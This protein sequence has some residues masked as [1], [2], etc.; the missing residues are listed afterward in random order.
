MFRV[1]PIVCITLLSGSVAQV[2]AD[3]PFVFDTNWRAFFTGTSEST[4]PWFPTDQTLADFDGDGDLDIAVA[5]RGSATIYRVS[6]LLN[7]GDGLFAPPVLYPIADNSEAI[8]SADFDGD[9]DVDILVSEDGT[10]N[11]GDTVALLRNNGDGTFAPREGVTVHPS[12]GATGLAAADL[13]GDGDIDFASADFGLIGRGESVSIRMNSGDG[14]F[15]DG[16]TLN[17]PPGPSGIIIAQLIGSPLPDIAVATEE[18]T[19]ELFENQD[20]SFDRTSLSLP[21]I[22]DNIFAHVRAADIDNDGDLDLGVVGTA[23]VTDGARGAAIL[24]NNGKGFDAAAVYPFGDFVSGASQLAFGELTGDGNLDLVG[25]SPL[26]NE[27]YILPGDGRGAFGSA[28]ERLSGRYPHAVDIADID[29]DGDGDV[30]ITSELSNAVSIHEN[31]GI[32][33][34]AFP[35]DKRAGFGLDNISIASGDIDNDGDLDVVSGGNQINVFVNLGDGTYQDADSFDPGSNRGSQELALHDLD[36]DTFLDLLWIPRDETPPYHFFV[37]TND[38]TGSFGPVQAWEIDTCG[39]EDIDA[40]DLDLDGDLDIVVTEWLGCQNVPLSAR[41]LFIAENLGDG[42]FNLLPPVVL[43]QPW[44]TAVAFGDFNEDGIPDLA[45]GTNPLSVGI[46]NG[47]LSYEYFEIG[48]LGIDLDVNDLNGD[49]HLDIVSCV[50]D[51]TDFRPG[52][53]VLLGNG[54][55]TFREMV[56]YLTSWSPGLGTSQKVEIGDYDGDGVLDLTILNGASN[57]LSFLKGAGDGTFHTEVRFG[58]GDTPLD[59]TIGD[60]NGDGVDDLAAAVPTLTTRS[61]GG[62]RWLF[63]AGDGGCPADLDGDEDVDADDFFAYLDIFAA[64]D[65]AADLDGDG[66]TDADDFFAYLDLFAAGC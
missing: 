61:G 28:R 47:D 31:D 4:Q 59:F 9:G 65:P 63:A 32:G 48:G 54:D 6:V 8:I 10:N 55:G 62:V 64:G 41:R 25:V 38:G 33:S 39:S 1:S 22:G 17:T 49:G 16:P 40:H 36:G 27:W 14:T 66:D 35:Y 52:A 11:F 43:P 7:L 60:F 5:N 19:V 13:D 20:G 56:N 45:L 34:F 24:L 2:L 37:A 57:D 29:G 30:V 12:D 23:I 46:G 42:T 3:Q 50:V 44:P 15:V 53:G 18:G 58:V 51:N 21:T 26:D